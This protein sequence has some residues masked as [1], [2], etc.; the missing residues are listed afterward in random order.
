MKWALV[1]Q[2]ESVKRAAEGNPPPPAPLFIVL[3]AA[4][5]LFSPVRGERGE[6]K[7]AA[8]FAVQ[9]AFC[10]K[11]NFT[12]LHNARLVSQVYNEMLQY[13]VIVLFPVG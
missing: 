9:Q 5:A 10:V 2:P 1:T 3:T 12:Q 8:T 11:C 7:A 6:R 4:G 13:D